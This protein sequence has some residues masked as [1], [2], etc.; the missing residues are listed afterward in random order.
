[1]HPCLFLLNLKVFLINVFLQ[2]VYYANGKLYIL[3]AD[4]ENQYSVNHILVLETKGG[5]TPV[6]IYK[7]PGTIYDSFAVNDNLIYAMNHEKN[8]IQTI[9]PLI[10]H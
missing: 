7:L 1:M 3:Y 5:L 10:S 4:W 9:K 6:Y 8:E 2:D